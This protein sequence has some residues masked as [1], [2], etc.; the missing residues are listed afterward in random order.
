MRNE[1]NTLRHAQHGGLITE[2]HRPYLLLWRTLW[3][4]LKAGTP[5]ISVKT[6]TANFTVRLRQDNLINPDG[7]G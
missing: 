5:K 7:R 6:E 1:N 3:R 4:E 2:T